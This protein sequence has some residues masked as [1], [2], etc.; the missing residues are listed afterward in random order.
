LHQADLIPSRLGQ[1]QSTCVTALQDLLVF[2]RTSPDRRHS[3]PSDPPPNYGLHRLVNDLR[4]Q[5]ANGSTSEQTNLLSPDELLTE[6]RMH[7]GRIV[8]QLSPRDADLAL[9]LVSLLSHLHRLAPLRA[10]NHTSLSTVVDSDP[11]STLQ[12]HLSD[13]Q[14]ERS[15]TPEEMKRGATPVQAVEAALIWSEVDAELDAVLSLCRSHTTFDPF[16][17]YLPPEYDAADELPQYEPANEDLHHDGKS[18]YTAGSLL[19]GAASR[20]SETVN[21]K[22]KMDLEAVTV[23]IERLYSV[24]P[25]LHNQRVELKK[26]KVEQMERAKQKGKQRAKDG[27][28]DTRDL[29][30]MLELINKAS[31]RKLN[32]QAV[33]IDESMMRKME[34]AKQKAEEKVRISLIRS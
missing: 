34:L 28:K 32:D 6:L 17:D 25:Q 27:D 12:R 31:T 4:T 8:G 19:N 24:A 11:Y 14:L 5:V 16:V 13:F 20:T 10:D 15:S 18:S 26:K 3:R 23:A 21:E 29:D 9:T 33:F 30:K 22:M 7:V 1:V 2:S